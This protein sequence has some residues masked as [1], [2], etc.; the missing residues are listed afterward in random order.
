MIINYSEFRTDD[1]MYKIVG[2][3][4]Y[5]K[6]N[7]EVSKVDFTQ[8]PDGVMV[9]PISYLI[10]TA[11]KE[12]GQLEL[13][14]RQPLSG[15]GEFTEVIGDFDISNFNE[16]NVNWKTQQEIEEGKNKPEEPSTEE[17]LK[18]AEETILFLMDMNL[19]GGM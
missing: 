6:H 3:T 12:N 18:M 17:R 8:L 19:I 4:I 5:I 10:T 13:T 2:E 1:L 11:K 7:N 14:L 16:V 15:I 9:E